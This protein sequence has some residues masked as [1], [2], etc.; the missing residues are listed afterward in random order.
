MC[1][2]IRRL[3]VAVVIEG[4]EEEKKKRSIED[5]GITWGKKR[6]IEAK[7]CEGGRWPW[8]EARGDDGW[9]KLF[10]RDFGARAMKWLQLFPNGAGGRS[11]WARDRDL[12]S[13]LPF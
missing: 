8:G 7:E 13:F 4:R 3:P 1:F 5:Y 11:S 2:G 12:G 10:V 9:S 6:V